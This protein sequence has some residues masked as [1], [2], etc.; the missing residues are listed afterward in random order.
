M[1]VD[2]THPGSNMVL[3][4]VEHIPA[5]VGGQGSLADGEGLAAEPGREV[6]SSFCC[7]LQVADGINVF[8]DL[9][10]TR[11]AHSYTKLMGEGLYQ[12]PIFFVLF[13]FIL[14]YFCIWR[15]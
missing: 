4:P 6:G 5:V 9:E 12:M 13:Y 3:I 11:L 10:R 14:F 1:W 2:V 8:E 15:E 7:H